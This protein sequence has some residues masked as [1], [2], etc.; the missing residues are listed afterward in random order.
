MKTLEEIMLELEQEKKAKEEAEAKLMALEQNANLKAY[1][2]D[3]A[4]KIAGRLEGY[5]KT[6]NETAAKM[7]DDRVKAMLGTTLPTILKDVVITPQLTFGGVDMQ[8]GNL[9][10]ADRQLLNIMFGRKA[11]MDIATSGEGS[12]WVPTPLAAEMVWHVQIANTVV[13]WLEFVNAPYDNYE[14]PTGTANPTVYFKAENTAPTA[15]VPTTSKM[16]FSGKKIIGE[17]D[18]S[19]EMDEN[20]IIPLLPTL[21][22]S[23]GKAIA[24]A[25]ERAVIWGDDTTTAASNIDKNVAAGDPQLAFNGL[26]YTAKGG[27]ATWFVA[28]G[29]DW[30]TSFRALRAAM[31][32]YAIDPLDLLVICPVYVMDKLR[33][34]SGFQTWD[35][36]GPMA[37][38]LTGMLPNANSIYKYGL[39]DGIIVAC[40]PYVYKSDNTG[41]RLTTAGSNT[42]YNAM[43]INRRRAFFARIKNQITVETDRDVKAQT[44]F[45]VMSERIHLQMPDGGTTGAYGGIKAGS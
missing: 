19:Y 36:V 15:A 7:V 27:T 44:N 21:K 11:A 32:K 14:I 33:S 1:A 29:T 26:W 41:V 9:K 13:P 24:D 34:H 28:Y 39:F 5:Q 31:D 37:S 2:D 16:T 22:T 40:S 25:E 43:L 38:A 20:A 8:H 3:Q 35:K 30:P 17:V 23:L 10:T 45:L 42:S 4:Q 12:Q 6:I 18:F